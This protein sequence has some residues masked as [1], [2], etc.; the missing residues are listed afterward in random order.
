M[1]TKIEHRDK[2]N[3]IPD[4]SLRYQQAD[5]IIQVKFWF[6]EL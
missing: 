2:L 5:I 3:L 4:E 1:H 6:M